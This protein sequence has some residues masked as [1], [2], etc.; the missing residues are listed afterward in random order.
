[1]KSH[2]V[3]LFRNYKDVNILTSNIHFIL[4]NCKTDFDTRCILSIT[5]KLLDGLSC[6]FKFSYLNLL[7]INVCFKI[8]T[9]YKAYFFFHIYIMKLMFKKNMDCNLYIKKNNQS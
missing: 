9:N 8:F 2:L 3:K 7:K 6:T 4:S 1:M 5:K